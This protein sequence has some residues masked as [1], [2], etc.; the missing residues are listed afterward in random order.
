MRPANTMRTTIT[1][2]AIAETEDL[3]FCRKAHAAGFSV[4]ADYALPSEQM[5]VVAIR[6]LQERNAR[7]MSE[8]A[9]R[10]V[11]AAKPVPAIWMPA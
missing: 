5:V 7:A 6:G 3:V 2:A 9:R 1:R 8:A 10:E 4:Y 11:I